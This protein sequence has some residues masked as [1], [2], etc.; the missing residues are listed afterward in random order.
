[1]ILF[2]YLRAYWI[3]LTINFGGGIGLEL[4]VGSKS[5]GI[6][7]E[8]KRGRSFSKA[9]LLRLGVSKR[10]LWGWSR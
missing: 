4:G 5:H 8:R 2:S 7:G 3:A 9:L 10:N 1:M 6:A